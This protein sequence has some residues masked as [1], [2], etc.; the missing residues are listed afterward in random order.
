MSR[1]DRY[2]RPPPCVN[3]LLFDLFCFTKKTLNII[4]TITVFV[5]DSDRSIAQAAQKHNANAY[6]VDHKN[7]QRFLDTTFH[8]DVTVYT[9]HS[10][11]PKITN[12]RAVL[13]EILNKADIIHYAPPKSWSDRTTDTYRHTSQQSLTLYFLLLINSIKKNVVNFDV[14][15]YQKNN[16][17][18]LKDIR[19]SDKKTLWSAGCS[20]AFGY[21]VDKSQRYANLISEATGLELVDLSMTGSCIEYSADQILRSD[22]R[23]HDVVIWGITEE[24]RFP[25]WDSKKQCVDS[26]NRSA[27]TLTETQ[28]YKSTISVHQVA[29][30]CNKIGADLIMIPIIC[31]ENFCLLLSGLPDFYQ[32]PYQPKFVDVGSDN[33]HPGPMQHQKYADFLS[34]IVKNKL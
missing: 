10:D 23:Q 12:D 27:K 7:Y 4:M 21:G 17:V 9:A 5:G 14:L 13:Y 22:I 32:F 20:I 18:L 34:N 25:E 3:S 8:H 31:S 2:P 19:H 33:Q 24:T 11:L 1:G 29:N 26:G 6:L 30:F 28:I 15:G 16:Y